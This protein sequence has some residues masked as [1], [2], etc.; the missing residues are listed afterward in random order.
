MTLA[1]EKELEIIRAGLTFRE[2][3]IHSD[4]PHWD[5]MRSTPGRKTQP[6][7]PTTEGLWKQRS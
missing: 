4:Q 1:D 3:D 5:A 2:S 6:L 7:F